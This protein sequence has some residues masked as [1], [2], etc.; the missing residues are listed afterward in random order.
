MTFVMRT[1][2]N[3]LQGI[4]L[5]KKHGPIVSIERTALPCKPDN[6]VLNLFYARNRW[7]QLE[8]FEMAYQDA[9]EWYNTITDPKMHGFRLF[10]CGETAFM[11]VDM[12]GFFLPYQGLH[13]HIDCER[14]VMRKLAT[15]LKAHVLTPVCYA[16]ACRS[17]PPETVSLP[18]GWTAIAV[19]G[20]IHGGVEYARQ[21]TPEEVYTWELVP[22]SKDA[23]FVR[24]GQKVVVNDIDDATVVAFVRPGTIRVRYKFDGVTEEDVDWRNVKAA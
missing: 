18:A 19:D 13:M 15:W 8:K 24:I 11:Y 17:R 4:I 14:D 1:K 5:E 10:G 9:Q 2:E 12:D 16:Y 6:H 22:Y 21:L 7:D 23:Y 3:G 20:Y